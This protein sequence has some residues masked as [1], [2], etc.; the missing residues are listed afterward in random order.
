MRFEPTN[1]AY[2]NH[3]AACRDIDWEIG[4]F[5]RSYTD[6]HLLLDHGER[7]YLVYRADDEDGQLLVPLITDGADPMQIRLVREN[8]RDGCGVFYLDED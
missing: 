3:L 5:N 1:T 8:C 4:I 7:G 2:E 6:Y